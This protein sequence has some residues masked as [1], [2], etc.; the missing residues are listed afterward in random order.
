MSF[1]PE[2]I[3]A[4]LAGRKVQAALLGQFDFASETMRLWNGGGILEA[5]DDTKWQGLG[6]WGSVT[7]LEQ[8]INGQAP[9]ATFTLSGIDADILLLTRDEFEEEVRGRMVRVLLQF[10]GTDDVNDPDNQR[11]LDNPFPIWAGL[12]LKP[13][14]TL[15]QETGERS[16]AVAA[17]SIFSQRGRPRFAMYTDAD[18]QK[19][20][21]GDRGFEFVASLINKETTWPDF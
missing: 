14:F 17:E 18:Q 12:M 10:F 4:H 7:G 11:P 15:D 13:T 1:F 6:Q 20:F 2:T 3:A 9:E 5:N 19:R 16:V 21:P 8:A